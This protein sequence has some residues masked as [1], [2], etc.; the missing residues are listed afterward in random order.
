MSAVPVVRDLATLEDAVGRA[1]ESGDVGSLTILGYGEISCVVSWPVGDARVAC[2]RLPPFDG[3]ARVDAYRT[4][5]ERYLAALAAHGVSVVP[6]DVQTVRRG[7][8]RIAVYCVQPTLDPAA[9]APALAA[10][11]P[12]AAGLEVIERISKT[13]VGAVG[14][15][16]GIDGQL[17]NWAVVGGDVQFLD[18]STPML[19]DDTGR[20]LLD[21]DL[22]IASLPWALRGVVRR[23][24]LGS[25][26][27]KYFDRRGVLLDLA[28]N[29]LK[30]KLDRLLPG[31]LE[32][33]NGLI[34]RPI[35]VG[36]AREYYA[37]DAR[38]WGW[39][40]RVRRLD[41]SWQRT[42]RRRPY[43]FLLPGRIER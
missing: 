35:T 43:P 37:S 31:A 11:R 26:L 15:T 12:D 21:T 10:A 2:K 19:R 40:Q 38:L 5:L 41:R 13:L 3:D 42:V 4:T 1:L 18:V 16:L 34:D 23:F 27:D 32:I 7:D 25:I 9:L 22:F 30:E 24:V 36:E 29:L 39:L 8:G 14:P 17:S 20:D 28:G 33:A 6:T